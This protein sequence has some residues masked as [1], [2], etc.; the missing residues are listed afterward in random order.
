MGKDMWE[1]WW[2]LKD[3]R[4]SVSRVES[5]GV[6]GVTR[7]VRWEN[8]LFDEVCKLADA[9]W[10]KDVC[11]SR[12]AKCVYQA[13]VLISRGAPQDGDVRDVH[14]LCHHKLRTYALFKCSLGYE[15][16]LSVIRDVYKRQLVSRLRMGVLPLRIETGRYEGNGLKGSRGI[17]V[18]FRVCLCCGSSKVED[19]IHF[20]LECS[21]FSVERKRLL[22]VCACEIG[23]QFAL[24]LRD[25]RA[26]FVGIMQSESKKVICALGE[27]VYLAYAKRGQLMKSMHV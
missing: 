24:P 14:Q 8:D 20:V 7:I 9:E 21:S 10:L 22:S 1:K 3:F 13:A 5:I 2:S 4:V 19:E 12:Q 23:A 15:M 11:L 18:E 6:R 25:V 16:Y 26:C 27:Y 17:P